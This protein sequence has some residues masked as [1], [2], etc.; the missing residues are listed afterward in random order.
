[1]LQPGEGR[2]SWAKLLADTAHASDGVLVLAV[3]TRELCQQIREGKM[4]DAGIID[5]LLH[6]LD[7]PY[8]LGPLLEDTHAAGLK[9]TGWLQPA[10][11]TPRYWLRACTGAFAPCAH[12]FANLINNSQH[13]PLLILP[14]APPAADH[15]NNLS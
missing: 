5:L 15:C 6:A 8:T 7:Q 13:F 1:M 11:Y 12:S 9:P 14:L 3:F 4:G 2:L 10:L